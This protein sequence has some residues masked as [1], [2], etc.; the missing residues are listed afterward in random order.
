MRSIAKDVSLGRRALRRHVNERISA[1][2]SQIGSLELFCECGRSRCAERVQV[3]ADAYAEVLA[4]AGRFLVTAGHA[5]DARA[6]DRQNGYVVVDT[7][8]GS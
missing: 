6:A 3:P 8:A 5:D 7:G 2:S 1:V 4:S